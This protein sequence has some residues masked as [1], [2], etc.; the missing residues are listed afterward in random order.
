M[1]KLRR[2]QK[3]TYCDLIRARRR[4]VNTA[5]HINVDQAV[6]D[7]ADRYRAAIGEAYKLGIPVSFRYLDSIPND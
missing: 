4:L 6:R 3:T 7:A 1:E 2:E 5:L